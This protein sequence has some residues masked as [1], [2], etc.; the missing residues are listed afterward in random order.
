[1]IF[2][3]PAA[4]DADVPERQSLGTR[5]KNDF[6]RFCNG[7]AGIL[8]SHR[9]IFLCALLLLAGPIAQTAQRN[10]LTI[11]LVSSS[12]SSGS[13]WTFAWS[14]PNPSSSGVTNYN[15]YEVTGAGNNL[16]ASVPVSASPSYVLDGSNLAIGNHTYVV[17]AVNPTGESPPSNQCSITVKKNAL[18]LPLAPTNLT[19]TPN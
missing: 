16:V 6:A 9:I 14:D 18:P 15:F 17:T 8:G 4:F 19:A 7:N 2:L 10:P 12:S 13:S 5:S 3:K 1:M 11:A